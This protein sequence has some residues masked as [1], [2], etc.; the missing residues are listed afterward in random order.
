MTVDLFLALMVFAFVMS[1]TPGPNNLMLLASGVNYGFRRSIPHMI[2]IS[3]GFMFM[4]IVMGFG[5]GQ[6]FERYPV[7]Y[8]IMRYGGGAY[9]LWLAWKI[10]NSGPIG[11]G[12]TSG[13]PMTLMQ[14]ALF[15]WVNPKAWAIT[16]SAIA[17]YTHGNSSIWPVLIIALV[18]GVVNFP[19]IGVWAMFG[20]LLRNL[21]MQ[22]KFLRI[23]NVSMAVLLVL[24]L[25]PLVWH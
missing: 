3:L 21:L 5:L 13:S 16:I 4:I 18:C 2:G 17:T 8:D 23:F 19:T 7:T 14:A 24:S 25:A 6:I 22:P 12:K 10:A 15:Q 20:V 9:M 11:E 1:V